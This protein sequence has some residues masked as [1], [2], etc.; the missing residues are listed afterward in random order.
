MHCHLAK[1]L[2]SQQAPLSHWCATYPDQNSAP[3]RLHQARLFR[4]GALQQLASPLKMQFSAQAEACLQAAV[5]IT[6]IRLRPYR[7]LLLQGVDHLLL[8]C[9]ARPNH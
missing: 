2:S 7:D 3:H 4:S 6:L 5:L 9:R 8:I 1:L